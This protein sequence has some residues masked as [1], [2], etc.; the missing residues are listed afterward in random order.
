MHPKQFVGKRVYGRNFDLGTKG[1][2]LALWVMILVNV[3]TNIVPG[4]ILSFWTSRWIRR[5]RQVVFPDP[6]PATTRMIGKLDSIS[7]CAILPPIPSSHGAG[8]LVGILS[9]VIAPCPQ[10]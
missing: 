7:S 9:T 10:V 4:L 6:G 3:P 1:P 2:P 5:L 8:S